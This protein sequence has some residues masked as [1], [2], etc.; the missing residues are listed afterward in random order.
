MLTSHFLFVCAVLFSVIGDVSSQKKTTE[1]PECRF[2][3]NPMTEV[4]LFQMNGKDL[5]TKSRAFI[6]KSSTGTSCVM[7]MSNYVFKPVGRQLLVYYF[8]CMNSHPVIL[9]MENVTT[10]SENIA[11]LQVKRCLMDNIEISKFERLYDLKV[12]SFL[13][14]VPSSQSWLGN[15]SGASNESS[16]KEVVSYT[17]N[18]GQYS[19]QVPWILETSATFPNIS[20]LS[21]TGLGLTEL[22]PDMSVRFPNLQSISLDWN[23]FTQV[24]FFPYTEKPSFLPLDLSR[25]PNMQNHYAN[26]IGIIIRTDIFRRILQLNNNLIQYLGDY[27]INGTLQLISINNNRL[28][29]ISDHAF[30]RVIGLQS[31]SLKNNSLVSINDKIFSPCKD[32]LKLQLGQNKIEWIHG[33]AFRQLSKLNELDLSSNNL[34]MIEPRTFYPLTSLRTLRLENNSISKFDQNVLQ[35]SF[36]NLRVVNL[37]HNKFQ[38]LPMLFFLLRGLEMVDFSHC[39][40]SIDRMSVFLDSI[41][42]TD[43][44]DSIIVSASNANIDFYAKRQQKRKINLSNNL[45]R[46]LDFRGFYKIHEKKMIL[47]LNNY[48]LILKGNPIDCDCHLVALLDF[49]AKARLDKR[50]D[51]TEYFYKKWLC[52]W[53]PEFQGRP[54]LSLKKTDLFCRDEIRGCPTGC[55]CY[56]RYINRVIIVNCS[57]S[58]FNSFPGEMP[59]GNLEIWLQY[60]NISELASRSYLPRIKILKMTKNSISS[61]SVP[62]LKQMRRIKR[63]WFDANL[64][65]T[66]P[67]EIQ[68]VNFELL[69]INTNHLVCDCHNQ[70]MKYW[71]LTVQSRV[72]DWYKIACST[73]EDKVFSVVKVADEDFVCIEAADFRK[74]LALGLSLGFAILFILVCLYLLFYYRLEVKVL[75]YIYFNLHPLD[76]DPQKIDDEKEPIDTLVVCS[77]SMIEWVTANVTDTLESLR[78]NVLDINRDFLV[79]MSIRE[80]MRMAVCRSKR[81]I[82]ILSVDSF[83]DPI[84]QLALT[85][86]HEK[87]LRERPMYMVLFLHNVKKC[88][89]E[90]QDLKKYLSSGRFIRTRD[91]MLKQKMLYMLTGS[92]DAKAQNME[93]RRKKSYKIFFPEIMHTPSPPNCVCYDIFISY[94]DRDYQFATG[95]LYPALHARGY[96]VCL[97]D[98]DFMVGTAKEENILNAIELSRR[99]LVIVTEKHVDDEWQLFTLRTAIERSLK[100]TSNYLLCMIAPNVD[101]NTL[102][103]ETRAFVSTHVI[104]FQDDP[105]FWQKLYR[106]IPPPAFQKTD[107]EKKIASAKET[108]NGLIPKSTDAQKS[109]FSIT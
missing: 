13:K 94:P 108:P 96:V 78:F 68:G 67:R 75:I 22:P 65:T 38:I 86:T 51:G 23:R 93:L 95:V 83:K 76:C 77:K 81:S 31:L 60:N 48:E 101:L 9:D 35:I 47:I 64:L 105:L 26:S 39:Q 97:P 20:E 37:S 18:T 32:L 63:L 49:F 17:I 4:K 29:N 2:E 61:L 16:I 69:V 72:H 107:P 6:I 19:D 33:Q 100:Q 43:F 71:L 103:P 25:T 82:V 59:E 54:L 8:L 53:P 12:L 91:T 42:E 104:I 89:I 58:N 102:D 30:D 106:S 24:P 7:R 21:F 90:N 50:F 28:R 15:N 40:I 27:I 11:Y 80:N 45:I 84:V 44:I 62:V 109:V 56:R 10:L 57:H 55:I 74:T 46:R 92:N 5:P 88:V 66:L 73:S 70:W 87:V 85:F 1:V 14:S 99:T 34:T 79:G 98:R 52:H 41:P 36:V 3:M